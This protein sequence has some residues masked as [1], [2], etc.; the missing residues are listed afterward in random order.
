MTE[1]SQSLEGECER[2]ERELTGQ[3]R[4]QASW[5]H[6]RHTCPSGILLRHG[7]GRLW[8]EGN[9]KGVV[10]LLV[11]VRNYCPYRTQLLYKDSKLVLGVQLFLCEFLA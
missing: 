7:C 2:D 6:M 1:K 5:K 8:R 10:Q 9:Q 11:G 3:T 4:T